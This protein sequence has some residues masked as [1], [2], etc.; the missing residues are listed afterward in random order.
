MTD[1][2]NVVAELDVPFGPEGAESALEPIAEYSGAVG[3]SDLG[4]TEIV[5]TLPATSLRQATTTALAVLHSYT[6][7]VRSLRVLTTEDYDREVG[8]SETALLSVQ[9]TAHRLGMTRQRVQQLIAAHE[10]P[11]IKIGSTWAIR[12]AHVPQAA[13]KST[14]TARAKRVKTAASGGGEKAAKRGGG[15][16]VTKRAATAGKTPATAT[17]RKRKSA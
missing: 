4:Y 9:E 12:E 11:A 14:T 7:T 5:F 17:A 10:L 8:T 6:W 1:S 13:A 15:E 2:Y 3:R 16:T